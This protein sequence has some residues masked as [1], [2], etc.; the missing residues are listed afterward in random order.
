MDE[1][2]VLRIFQN[3][4]EVIIVLV[5]FILAPALIVGFIISMLQAATQINEVTLSFI[6]KLLVTLVTLIIGGPW[7]L[8][9]ILNY[10]TTLIQD[11]PGLIK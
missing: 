2:Q 5:S 11:I 10:T 9:V 8:G 1:L 4:L 6:P 7:V 3:T